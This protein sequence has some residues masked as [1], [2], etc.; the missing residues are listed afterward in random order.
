MRAA[1]YCFN[2]LLVSAFLVA[3]TGTAGAG[4]ATNAPASTKGKK[5]KKPKPLKHVRVHVESKHDLPERSLEASI[6]REDPLKIRV[7]KL[8]ILSEVHL[9]RA[10]LLEQPGGFMLQLKFNSL[11]TRI[12]ESYTA[13]AAGRHFAIMADVDG[14]GRWLALPLV[15]QRIG[16]GV[17][18]FSPDCTREIADRL[19]QGLNEEVDRNRRQWLN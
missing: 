14:E 8:P 13:A 3:G 17:L 9:E 1:R 15:R 7:E 16:T 19:V 18:A 4:T 5:E 6:G 2:L 10:A 12:L 11:G